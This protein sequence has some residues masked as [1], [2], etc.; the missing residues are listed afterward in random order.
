[1]S[2]FRLERA[3]TTGALLCQRLRRCNKGIAAL[4]FGY[5][6]P[7]M[8]MMFLGTVELSQSITVDRRV[9]QVASATADLVAR[10]TSVNEATL[11]DYM[12]IIEQL[13]QP[14]AADLLHL[15]IVSVYAAVP[16]S[17]STT[18][19]PK[20]CWSYNRKTD[21]GVNTYTDEQAYGDSKATELLA[22]GGRSII[23]AEV[24]YDYEPLIFS[25]FIKNT[26]PMN[27]KFYLAPR[28]SS[29]VQN[30]SHPSS[31]SPCKT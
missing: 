30:G 27:E 17:A 20:V 25:Y 2:I 5:V 15:T 9:S 7:I 6:V 29:S 4:E 10:Q 26:M 3:A 31:E 22:G 24:R 28:R 13:M 1:M 8:L 18:V 11:D 21:K 23:I 19:T 16:P 14:Y 12:L